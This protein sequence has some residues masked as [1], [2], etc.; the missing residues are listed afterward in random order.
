MNSS[1]TSSRQFLW[2]FVFSFFLLSFSVYAAIVYLP[3]STNTWASIREIQ[4]NGFAV[5]KGTS[6]EIT[7]W[8]ECKKVTAGS[9]N[10][11]VPTLTNSEWNQFKAHAGSVGASIAACSVNGSCGWS[12][13]N[14]NAGS[15]SGYSAGSCGGS[16]TWN[17]LGSGGWSNASCSIA[18]A[19]CAVNY[20]QYKTLWT[21][22]VVYI[23]WPSTTIWAKSCSS[24]FWTTVT[25]AT[26]LWYPACTTPT[27]TWQQISTNCETSWS[28]IPWPPSASS[29]NQ[30][31]AGD[32]VIW[33]W[34]S[35]AGCPY[36]SQELE[37]VCQ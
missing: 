13:N 30:L 5:N 1:H 19:A 27:C 32:I 7:V 25:N 31:K 35:T 29:C 26:N 18:N 17:C 6:K 37:C 28:G 3:W 22:D 16:K 9:V 11:F 20:C 12:A 24:C 21:G 14:C 8:S 34:W 36:T 15:P 2:I 33:R 23:S 10:V 4:G